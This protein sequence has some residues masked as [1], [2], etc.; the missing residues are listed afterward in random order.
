VLVVVTGTGTEVGKTW[1]AAATLAALR[2]RGVPVRAR[3]PVQSFEPGTGP[4]DA[5]V[6]AAAT[7]EDVAAVC[8]RERWYPV[9]MAP[10]MAAAALGRVAPTL[11]DLVA[12]VGGATDGAT[13]DGVVLVEGAGGPRSPLAA[14]G[15]TV[16]LAARL[17]PDLVVLV[18][19]A[20]LGTINAVRLAAD[21]LAGQALAVALNRFDAADDLHG[22]NLAWLRTRAGL[23]V[24]TDP[25]AL[26][27]RLVR[28]TR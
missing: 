15:D 22:A 21:A 20:G 23:E 26:V 3:K 9:P 27:E 28:A 5:E 2:A 10:P 14:D 24:V 12:A 1:W 17:A 11:D 19:D 4:T 25:E 18:A 8:P 6:L 13:R 7:G 16:D